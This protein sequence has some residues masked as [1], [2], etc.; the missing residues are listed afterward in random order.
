MIQEIIDRFKTFELPYILNEKYNLVF[1]KGVTADL[2][3]HFEVDGYRIDEPE[4]KFLSE[5]EILPFIDEWIEST[6]EKSSEIKQLLMNLVMN[7]DPQGIDDLYRILNQTGFLE[8]ES[9]R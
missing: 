2:V 4:L 5:E 8:R 3:V 7:L 1:V 6:L 9:F